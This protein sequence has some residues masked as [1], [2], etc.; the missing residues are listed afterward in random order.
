MDCRRV[1]S[2][3][4]D[5]LDGTLPE[6]D[7]QE[8]ENHI[9]TCPLCREELEKEKKVWSLVGGG[10]DVEVGPGFVGKVIE[11]LEKKRFIRRL[12]KWCA[13]L[14]LSFAL[15]LLV[16][17]VMNNRD[18]WVEEVMKDKDLL[19][20]LDVLMRVSD[21]EIQAAMLFEFLEQVADWE[22]EK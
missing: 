22:L 3:F 10:I 11:E 5:Y 20:S 14:V 21:E 9:A 17:G 19:N 18:L 8:M 2:L 7:R 4:E 6:R 1:K 13:V 15:S 12:L 16:V